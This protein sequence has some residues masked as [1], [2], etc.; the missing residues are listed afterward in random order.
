[1]VLLAMSAAN[2]ALWFAALFAFGVS[3]PL[4]SGVAV[5]AMGA[6]AIL[7]AIVTSGGCGD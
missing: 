5:F 4:A 3:V 7:A 6:S 2:G 1:M